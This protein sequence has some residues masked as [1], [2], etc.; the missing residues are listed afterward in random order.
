MGVN[1]RRKVYGVGVNDFPTNTNI[2]G[3]DIWEYKR[4][5]EMLRRGYDVA[6]KEK[7]PTYKDVFVEDHLHS[8]TNFYNHIKTMIGYGVDGYELDKDL[9]FKDNKCYSRDTIVFVPKE[10]NSFLV[11]AKGSGD[12]PVGVS[13]CVLAESTRYKARIRKGDKREYLG[14]YDTPDEAYQAYKAEKES[15][16]SVLAEK[17]K[18]EIDERAYNALI[19]YTM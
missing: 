15:Y 3:K 18:G 5:I 2:D 14:L 6:Y 10:I 12:L 17:W 11:N 7:N 16:A 4:W 1:N 9:L 13:K 8:F 19:N